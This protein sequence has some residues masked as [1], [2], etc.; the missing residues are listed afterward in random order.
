MGSIGIIG[1][2]GATKLPLTQVANIGPGVLPLLSAVA[3]LVLCCAFFIKGKDAPKIKWREMVRPPV[4]DGWIFYGLNFVMLTLV[5]WVGTIAAMFVFTVT[6]L[7]CAR[8][9]SAKRTI[10]FSVFWI[11]FM[12]VVF[13]ILLKVPFE[14]GVLF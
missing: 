7:L 8:K 1:I 9:L 2:V 14:R 3:L 11:G 13:E 12:Y 10:L 5:Y 4:L 6:A